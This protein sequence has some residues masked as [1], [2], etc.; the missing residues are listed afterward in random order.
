MALA[1]AF[2]AVPAM[3]QSPYSK[4]VFIGDSLTDQGYF[5]PLLP[6]SAQPVTGQFTTNPGWVW[7]QHVADYYGTNATANGNGQTGDNY[8]VGGAR[9]GTDSTGALGFTPS[10]KTQTA[11]YLAANGGKADANALYSVWGGANDLL[12][13][14]APAQAPAVIGAAVSDQVGIVA[15]LKNAGAQ[16]VV[17]PTLPDVGL[18][19]RFRQLG[20]AGMA[21]GTALATAYNDALFD[22]LSAAGLQVI[23]VDTFHMLQEI[24]AA[25]T[26]YGFTNVSDTAC[27]PLLAPSALLCNPLNYVAPDAANTYVFADSIHPTTATH[28]ILGQYTLSVLEA[29]RLQQVLTRSAQTIGRSRA[30]QVN[31]HRAG[32][33]G[34]GLSWWGSVRGDLQRF[35]HGDVYDGAAPAGLFGV[36]W[37]QDGIVLG[38]FAGFGKVDADFGNSRGDFTQQDT[39]AGLFA[40]WYGERAW[41]N[42]QVSYTWMSYDV[43]RKVQLGPATRQHS[44]SPDGSNLTAAL[45]AGYEFGTEGGFRHGPI[46]S[47][48]WQ[49]VKIDGYTENA[50]AGTL[51][52]ALGYGNQDVDSTVGRIG[53]QA[54]FDGGSLKPYAQLTYDHEFEDGQQASAWLQSMPE[55][56]MYKVPGMDFDQSYG[57][58]ILGA[59]TEL[60]GLQSNIGL[61]RTL[62]QNRSQDL[63]VFASF[64]GSF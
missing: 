59:R 64:T 14:T 11:N 4:T 46:A 50:D 15:T 37:A 29:P 57:T 1:V 42:G 51:A 27:N 36:D 24:V 21:Q 31:L 8:A 55:V 61:L 52:T 13:I 45:N 63:T 6:A 28:Q 5:R 3:A 40:G 58:A 47:V 20:A 16:Y 39:T 26:T 7:A 22:G 10:L 62:G 54:R 53:W 19:P 18:T 32:P 44:G 35:D 30:D 60:F 17:V 33:A 49:K 43:N 25:P 41:V 48:I 12:A 56:G 9:V 34:D 2:A 38:G 23:P